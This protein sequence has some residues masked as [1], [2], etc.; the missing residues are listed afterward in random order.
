MSNGRD[1]LVPK[2]ITD[3]MGRNTTVWVRSD[4]ARVE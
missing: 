3:S 1:G 4:D 2:K